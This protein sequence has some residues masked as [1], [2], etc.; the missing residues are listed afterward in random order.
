[1][2]PCINEIN[3]ETVNDKVRNIK[4][5]LTNIVLPNVPSWINDLGKWQDEQNAY[6]ALRSQVQ[7]GGYPNVYGAK[8]PVQSG[9]KLDK[10]GE[11]LSQYHDKEIIEFLRYRFPA[12][13]LPGA[14]DP[15]PTFRN[16]SS[17]TLYPQ[18]VQQYIRKQL[19]AQHIF[20]PFKHP[21]FRNRHSI[22]PLST[23]P[24]KDGQ[25]RCTILDLSFP[26]GN[27]VNE[28]TRKI[29]T[30]DSQSPSRTPV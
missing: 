26:L 30:W 16:H 6:V 18:F 22:S 15:T 24:K 10:F 8:I 25:A 9:W 1:M 13:R 14:P 28:F 7:Q 11:L 17:A 2:L 3:I 27:S 20:G 5:I 19:V 23:R 21:P 12:N 4:G 29:I